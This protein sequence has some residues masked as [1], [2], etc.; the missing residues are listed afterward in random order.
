M[1]NYFNFKSNTEPIFFISWNNNF[2]VPIKPDGK[3]IS[4]WCN[5]SSTIKQYWE[6][7]SA[8]LRTSKQHIYQHIWNTTCQS[9]SS[10]ISGSA[11]TINQT[12]FCHISQ[13]IGITKCCQISFAP[14]DILFHVNKITKIWNLKSE[15]TKIGMITMSSHFLWSDYKH[16]SL[17]LWTLKRYLIA[18]MHAA[19]TK[20]GSFVPKS[21]S[22]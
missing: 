14:P 4:T 16:Y 3:S 15:I 19:M 10:Y 1:A 11:L 20:V 9:L 7:S 17:S 18:A 8:Y 6:F 5:N 21:F 12:S 2:I 22:C 13:Q